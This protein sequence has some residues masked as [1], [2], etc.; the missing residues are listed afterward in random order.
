MITRLYKV[1]CGLRSSHNARA[2]NGVGVASFFDV[3]DFIFS[4]F[5]ASFFLGPA[6][7]T[8]QFNVQSR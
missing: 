7:V 2:V 6:A 8:V 4:A 5:M 3:D 1:L